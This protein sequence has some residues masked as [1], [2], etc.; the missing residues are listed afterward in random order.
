MV[1]VLV[2]EV[3]KEVMEEEVEEEMM[4]EEEKEIVNINPMMIVYGKMS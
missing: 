3:E 1:I 4:E 2:E